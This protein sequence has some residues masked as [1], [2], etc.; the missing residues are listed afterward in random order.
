[1]G[2]ARRGHRRGSGEQSEIRF[3]CV[4]VEP[5]AGAMVSLRMQ[6]RIWT[7]Y[8]LRCADESFYA[9]ITTSLGA[10]IE[11]HNAGSGAKYTR[12][13]TP[14]TLA[15]RKS[16]QTETEA[17]KLEYALKQL[18]RSQKTRIAEGDHGLWRSLRALVLR[19][20]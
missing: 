11:A 5:R 20:G 1:M 7:L 18:S 13:R 9:G 3:K 14:V 6:K 17:R 16:R 4:K 19:S 2:A 10:R 15:W 8:L 12:S